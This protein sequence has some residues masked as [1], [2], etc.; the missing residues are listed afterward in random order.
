M[1]N[2][3]MGRSRPLS[4][5]E[6]LILL[7]FFVV[8]FILAATYWKIPT[9]M[10]VLLC[11]VV[12]SAYG[13]LVLK[14]LLGRNVSFNRTSLPPWNR[15]DIDTL[16]CRNYYRQLAGVR[17]YSNANL[18]RLKNDFSHHLFDDCIP[19]LRHC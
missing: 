7:V 16:V 10:S 6:A 19:Y 8:F 11:A 3:N 2:G 1:D 12:A 17:N 4:F 15:S 9:G 14:N 18:L 5:V 13:M